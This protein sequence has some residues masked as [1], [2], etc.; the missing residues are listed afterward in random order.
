MLQNILTLALL[1]L[2][3]NASATALVDPD[4]RAS[5][6]HSSLRSAGVTQPIS[7]ILFLDQPDTSD[8]LLN[9][10]KGIPGVEVQPLQFMPAVIATIP[11]QI[12]VI[13]Q[14]STLPNVA[15]LSLNRIGQEE[16]V[17]STESML[18]R[19]SDIYPAVNN[20]WQHGY[21]GANGVVG[22]IDSGIAVEHPGLSGKTI[23]I[24]Q[25][26]GS[27]YSQYKNGVRTAHGTGVACIYAGDGSGVFNDDKG[28][29]FGA[30][31]IVAGIAGED[32]GTGGAP[33]DLLQTLS[34]LD[35]MLTRASLQPT[36]INYSFGNGPVSCSTC[37]DWSGLAKIVDYVVNQK[38]ILWA[39]SAGNEGW[40]APSTS[41][42][43]NATMTIPA[44]NYNGITVANMNPTLMINGNPQQTA[45]RSLQTIRYT[46]S[47]GPTRNGRRKPDISAPGNDTRTCAPDPQTYGILY[48]PEMDYQ[49]GYRLMGGTSSAAPHV[50][51]ALLLLQEAGITDPKAEKALLINS[52]DAWMDSGVPSPD[53]PTHPYKGGHYPVMGTEWNRT[54]GWGYINMEAAYQQ[55]DN[56]IQDSLTLSQPVKEYRTFLPIGGK[57]TL[58]HERRVGYL[59]DHSEWQLSPLSL[60]IVDATTQ[61]SI[62]KDNSAIDSVHQVANCSRAKGAKICSSQTVG[63]NVIIRIKLLN[64]TIDG[65]QAEPFAI[66]STSP[67]NQ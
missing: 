65:A 19:P 63:K 47:R 50:G 22:L 67:I 29:A 48:T 11:S 45:D 38:K 6:E 23:E 57:V 64:S 39:K 60:E 61:H 40:V 8:A 27:R 32:D 49:Y 25:E 30:T 18:L 59:A 16:M 36:V 62:M 55:R 66:V 4:L 9:T 54:Y 5:V 51:G 15:Q 46:S 31:Q 34:T 56:I 13:D 41:A 21:T 24:R 58:V 3:A 10:I 33:E 20:W 35:W 52:A 43:F 28:V 44:D 17:I 14:L 12:H 37:P 42:P 26:T 7:I 2:T 53:D 1:I